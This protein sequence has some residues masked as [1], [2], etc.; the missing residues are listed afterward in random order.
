VHSMEQTASQ[1]TLLVKSR[2]GSSPMGAVGA[3]SRP[4]AMAHVP[5]SAHGLPVRPDVPADWGRLRSLLGAGC[6]GN[7]HHLGFLNEAVRPLAVS[8]C[9]PLPSAVEAVAHSKSHSALLLR[10]PLMVAEKP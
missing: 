1:Q 9:P 2:K 5:T 3:W 4:M 8:A 10:P 6:P 7:G